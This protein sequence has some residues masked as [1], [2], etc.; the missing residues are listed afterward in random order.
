MIITTTIV[1]YIAFWLFN[2]LPDRWYWMPVKVVAAI[3]DV[4]AANTVYPFLFLY[5][6]NISRPTLSQQIQHIIDDYHLTLRPSGLQKYRYRIAMFFSVKL[7]N[8]IDPGH[9][10]I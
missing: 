8:P 3:I 10:K 4:A 5:L 7:I 6:P 2:Y 1:L 9:I